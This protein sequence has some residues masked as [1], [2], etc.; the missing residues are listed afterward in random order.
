L[1][2]SCFS[3]RAAGARKKQPTRASAATD[4]GVDAAADAG[5]DAATDAGACATTF[6]N[7]T[8][9]WPAPSL[10]PSGTAE[11]TVIAPD[12]NLDPEAFDNFDVDA[13]STADMDGI[14]LT[15]TETD[16][17]TGI[18]QGT[19][20]FSTSD[21]SS[22]HRLHVSSPDMVTVEFQRER[23]TACIE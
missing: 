11:V 8:V 15:V 7:G 22:G 3:C 4:A 6:E 2:R 23:A 17:N 18:F 19:V 21:E 12:R 13:W 5:V 16:E 10:P 1:G 14:D 20:F 9:M